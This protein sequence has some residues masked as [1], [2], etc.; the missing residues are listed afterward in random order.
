MK[1]IVFDFGNVVGF[2]DHYRTLRRLE[3][4]TT[5][6][7]EA[8]YR[9][10]YAGQLEEDFECGLIGEQEFLSHFIDRCRLACPADVLGEVCADIFWPNSEVCELVSKLKPR[11]RVL[12]GSNT[13]IIHAR[14][15]KQQFADVLRHFDDLVLSFEI[16]VRKPRPGFF[17]HCQKLAGSAAAECVFIDDLAENVAAA[18]E[19]GWHGIV[20][21]PGN[22]LPGALRRLGIEIAEKTPPA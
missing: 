2:F 7:A 20:Y 15:F 4:H 8:M 18:Q 13:N 21:K 19:L 12:L 9:A 1:T 5:L 11:Y 6:S 3:P 16:G 17:E 22:D 14:Y 10:V